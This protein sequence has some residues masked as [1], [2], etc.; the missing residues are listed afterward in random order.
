MTRVLIDDL[1][2]VPLLQEGILF[3]SL[4]HQGVYAEQYP[5][6]L[7]G[8]LDVDA[9]ERAFHRLVARHAALRTGFVWE[10]VPSTV[11]VVFRHATPEC[12][13]LDW[14]HLGPDEWAGPFEALMEEDYRRAFDMRRAPLARMA[15]V[16]LGPD[17]HI[18]LLT[19]HHA[20]VDGWSLPLVWGDWWALYHEEKGGRP[21]DLPP[22]PRFR[23]YVV[24]VMRQDR[25]GH[26]AFWRSAL[27]GVTAPTPLPLSPPETLEIGT[28][29][30]EMR[31]LD[32]EAWRRLEAFARGCAV[33]P[34]TLVQGAWGLLLARYAGEDES[35]SGATVSGRPPQVPGVER[36]VGMFVN[37]LPVRVPAHPG[38]RVDQWLAGL[39]VHI[40]EMLEHCH[41][42]LTDVRE[43]S[44]LP[45][46]RPPFETLVVYENYPASTSGD[47][48]EGEGESERLSEEHL[49]RSERA[50]F[51][52]T[53]VVV[54][55]MGT[56]VLR[57]TYH[58]LLYSAAAAAAI[59]DALAALI[60]R[61][62]DARGRRLGD[63]STLTDHE[64][65][66]L[67]AWERGGPAAS[68]PE[69]VHRL[70]ERQA[71]RAPGAAAVSCGGRTLTYARFDAAAET[72]ARRLRAL[73]V[74]PD[75]RVAVSLERTPGMAVALLAVLKAGGCYVA[76]DPAYP[77]ERRAQMLDDCGAR[78]VVTQ[79]SLAAALPAT[80]AR[81]LV[82]DEDGQVQGDDFG[83]ENGDGARPVEVDPENL[84]YVV[85][86]SGSTGRAK[87]VAMPH[88][89]LSRLLQWQAT[90]RGHGAPARTLQFASLSFDLSVLEI[91]S[92]WAAG[93]TL[94][95]VDEW[96]RRDPE[97]LLAFLRAERVERMFFPFAALRALAEAAEGRDAHLPHLREVGTG[98]EPMLMT[99]QLRAFFAANPQAVLENQYGP[100]E[101]HVMVAA[102][103]LEGAADGWETL[104][105]IGRPLA[106]T[107]LYV[108]DRTLCRAPAGA[109]GE[110]CVGGEGLARG[111][112]GRAALTAGHFVPDPFAGVPGAR[113]YRTGD[114][115]RWSLDGELEFLGRV[116]EQVKVRGHRVEPGEVEVALAAHPDV[117]AAV[118]VVRDDG[119]GG[120]LAAYVVPREGAAPPAAGLRDH[121]AARL[122]E[123]MVPASY[124]VLEAF[125]LTPS[126]KVDRR[127]LP[128]PGGEA[129]TYVA[130]RTPTE[131][132]LAA[133][134]GELLRVERVG[135]ADNFFHL[136]G[137]SLVIMR[138]ASQVRA[139]FEVEV[140]LRTLYEAG[141]LEKQAAA[142][143]ALRNAALER[144]V[145]E[146][147]AMSDDEAREALAAEDG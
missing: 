45:R 32:R 144:M 119:R 68:A 15:T 89:A 121:L 16:H 82:V 69:P 41:V 49:V 120:R 88:R 18:L 108:L 130:P 4:L 26:E 34:A 73:G 33:T 98:G 39:Q 9:L 127:A 17:D 145:A 139:R 25:A 71:A 53:L 99:R 101:A 40:A 79:P 118:V 36:M 78:V 24:W 85:Y 111:Y 55:Y 23:D 21:A 28:F 131:E 12:R 97:A 124:T 136:G 93:G 95:L 66:R 51:S 13:R 5:R 142:I 117:G 54:P 104:P 132:V 11:Q 35:V 61:L 57:L 43:W 10:N 137:H 65:A 112:L 22:A 75:A 123:H 135:A 20:V 125:P 3:H 107:R 113:M 103:P 63:V 80:A 86:T 62:A 128:E 48:G 90:W 110:L 50:G 6:R 122:P 30:M 114:R 8:A 29:P 70:I 72:M 91:F 147:E 83:G 59:A 27:A 140:P 94:V 84:A 143:D 42:R 2:P 106:G 100:S 1:Y 129:E 58:S 105:P 14:T 92:T 116:D 37:S 56:L 74:G 46:D 81:L 138:L 141:V 146:L 44:E 19:A 31:V 96:T 38:L 52:L 133:V 67:D 76:I 126:G 7:R 64:R 47:A 134:W 102:H 109:P 115:A 77:A 60:P 87:G